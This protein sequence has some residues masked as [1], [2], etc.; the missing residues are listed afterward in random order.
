MKSPTGEEPQ[1]FQQVREAIGSA[2][3]SRACF[4]VFLFSFV[5]ARAF[6]TDVLEIAAGLVAIVSGIA[7][8]VIYIRAIRRSGHARRRL[9]PG[10]VFDTQRLVIWMYGFP[11]AR[12]T[13]AEK[14]ISVLII[15]GLVSFL[16]TGGRGP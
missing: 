13:M 9:S 4:A 7:L 16:F 1:T 11:A 12:D 3:I 10:A 5:V 14:L 2:L 8:F 6:D 15:I